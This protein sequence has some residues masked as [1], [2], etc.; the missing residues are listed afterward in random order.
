MHGRMHARTHACIQ[1]AALPPSCGSQQWLVLV[2]PMCWEPHCHVDPCRGRDTASFTL[3]TLCA[4]C[5]P[6][7]AC[8]LED[9]IARLGVDLL[10]SKDLERV[11]SHER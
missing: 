1:Q 6:R 11:L 7:A 2:K 3:I 8:R 10:R 9:E 4:L 5:V